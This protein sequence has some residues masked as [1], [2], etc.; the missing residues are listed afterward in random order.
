MLQK[1]F[2]SF[3]AAHTAQPPTPRTQFSSFSNPLKTSPNLVR[4]IFSFSCTFFSARLYLGLSQT[5]SLLARILDIYN[6]KNSINCKE[7]RRMNKKKNSEIFMYKKWMYR[8]SFQFVASNLR[9]TLTGKF[10]IR[11]DSTST[12]WLDGLWVQSQSFNC[13]SGEREKRNKNEN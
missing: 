7:E 8:K 4:F 6:K 11:L 12:W 5:S 3:I 9:K 10:T 1:W 13:C 2:L